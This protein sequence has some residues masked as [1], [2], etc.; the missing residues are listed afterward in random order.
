MPP[1]IPLARRTTFASAST[2][3]K[4]RWNGTRKIPTPSGFEPTMSLLDSIAVAMT[5]YVKRPQRANADCH[6]GHPES[7][8]EA[9]A[10]VY[11]N[12]TDTIR[13]RILGTE[14]TEQELDF[15]D[16]HDG[17]RGLAFIESVVESASSDQKWYPVKS[18]K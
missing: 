17:A 8:I 10:N 6:R 14:P 9:F 7:F 15:P 5:I 3:R 2:A 18:W 12:A 13:A 1:S 11:V 16:V 4:G